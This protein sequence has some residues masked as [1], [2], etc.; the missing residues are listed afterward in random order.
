MSDVIFPRTERRSLLKAGLGAALAICALNLDESPARADATVLFVDDFGAGVSPVW[1]ASLPAVYGHHNPLRYDGVATPFETTWAGSP[2]LRF[3]RLGIPTVLRLNQ[4]MAPLAHNGLLTQTAYKTNAFRYEVR[5]NTRTQGPFSLDPAVN[6]S[7]DGFIEI[8]LFDPAD[9][10]R[11]DVTSLF[12]NRYHLERTFQ[13]NSGI[14]GFGNGW[15]NPRNEDG[16]IDPDIRDGGVLSSYQNDTWY[17]LVLTGAAGQNI[18]AQLESDDGQI[19]SSWTFSHDISGFPNGFRLG[20]AQYMGYPFATF[21][22]DVAIDYVRLT[23]QATVPT[24]PS[25]SALSPSSAVAG[26]AGFT[27]LVEGSG[28]QVG[29]TVK[30]QNQA[31]DTTVISPTLL[32]ATVSASLLVRTATANISAVNAGSPPIPSL[33]ALRF[34]VTN[35]LPTI[36]ISSVP[37]TADVFGDG[38]MEIEVQNVGSATA[39]GVVFDPQD[40][41]FQPTTTDDDRAYSLTVISLPETGTQFWDGT[42]TAGQSVRLRI[43][44]H[45]P[46]GRA[47]SVTLRGRSPRGNFIAGQVAAVFPG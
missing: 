47:G 23:G 14:D 9:A 28:F 43:L 33:N 40:Q 11:Y 21:P 15:H 5:F 18:A 13:A 2:P 45:L 36:R 44:W 46:H 22:V 37:R 6:H 20:I 29:T 31:L 7:I 10:S 24:R 19:L 35:A 34:A 4:P 32:S 27:L 12:G 1:R 38:R 30:W 39:T 16:T 25:L 41:S 17:K 42:L 8:G 26:G 3:E